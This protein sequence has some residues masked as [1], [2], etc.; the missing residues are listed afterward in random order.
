MGIEL[1]W[2][3]GGVQ[4]KPEEPADCTYLCDLDGGISGHFSVGRGEVLLV[5]SQHDDG[6]VVVF[7]PHIGNDDTR[8][9]YTKI[10]RS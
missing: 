9:K 10:P 3:A 6:I 4:V 1:G 5:P 7:L 2:S 8:K